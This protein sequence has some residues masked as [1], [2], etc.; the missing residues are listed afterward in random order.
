MLKFIKNDNKNYEVRVASGDGY[1]WEV[2]GKL[3]KDEDGVWDFEYENQSIDYEDSLKETEVELKE[4][5]K[6]GETNDIAFY[7]GTY[8]Y[9]K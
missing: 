6:N 1:D 7:F 2:A 9:N 8:K 3:V 4:D 5:F